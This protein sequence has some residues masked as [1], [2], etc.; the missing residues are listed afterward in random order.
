ML[1]QDRRGHE[2][3]RKRRRTLLDEVDLEGGREG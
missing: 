3:K 2:S 1:G